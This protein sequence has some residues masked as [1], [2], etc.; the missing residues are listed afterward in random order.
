MR[1]CHSVV[2]VLLLVVASGCGGSSPTRTSPTPVVADTSV[3]P[4]PPPLSCV[5]GFDQLRVN[6]AAFTTQADCGVTITASDASWQAV[7][8]YGRPAPFVWFTVPAGTTA[9]GEITVTSSGPFTF[10][11]VDIYSSTTKIPY[12]IRGLVN[13]AAIFTVQGIQGNTFGAFATIAS[14]SPTAPIDAL[15]I[16][17]TNPAAPCCANPVGLDNI[18]VVR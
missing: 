6:H 1:I 4:P 11:S 17:L 7:T 14:P 12:E 15:R 9:I 5:I 2:S 8:T 16:R 3:G 13:G 18:R 10:Q